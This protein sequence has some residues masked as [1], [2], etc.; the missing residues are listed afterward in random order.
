MKLLLSEVRPSAASCHLRGKGLGDG[1][2]AQA[3]TAAACRAT[4]VEL[5]R[6]LSQ[7]VPR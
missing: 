2:P 1:E 4:P 3:L 7:P 5:L 6:P